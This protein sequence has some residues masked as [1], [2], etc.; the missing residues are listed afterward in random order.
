MAGVLEMGRRW[1]PDP[2]L[3]GPVPLNHHDPV[4]SGPVP[5][6]HHDPVLSGPVPLNHHDL[7][8]KV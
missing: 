1:T 7:L 3:S 2:V 4:L 8:T 6:N 5:L